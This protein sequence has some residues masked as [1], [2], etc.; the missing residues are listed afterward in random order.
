MIWVFGD[1]F[2]VNFE[3]FGKG[4]FKSIDNYLDSKGYIPKTY[5]QLL[6]EELNEDITNL[7]MIGSDNSLIILRIMENYNKI[8]ENDIVL[9]NWTAIERFK[10][11]YVNNWASSLTFNSKILS[12]N[13]YD[14]IALLRANILYIKEQL[15]FIKFVEEIFK[16]QKLFQWTWQTIFL[17]DKFMDSTIL[18]ETNDKIDDIH[19]GEYGHKLLYNHISNELKI[20]RTFNLNFELWEWMVIQHDFKSNISKKLI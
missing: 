1:S 4:N 10:I 11:A 3:D 13:V 18:K 16:T 6:A 9:I 20:K 2:S 17:T 5:S 7:S 8:K 15:T 14:E 12:R 19:Y